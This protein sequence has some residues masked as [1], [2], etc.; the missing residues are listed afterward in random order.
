VAKKTTRKKYS[1]FA[2]IMETT[3]QRWKNTLNSEAPPDVDRA[4]ALLKKA[5]PDDQVFVVESPLQFYLAQA[6]I[7]GR[8]SRLRATRAC[9]MFYDID[10]AF[11]SKLQKVGRPKDLLAQPGRWGNDLETRTQ[12]MVMRDFVTTAWWPNLD[13]A[14]KLRPVTARS[15]LSFDMRQTDIV[16]WLVDITTFELKYHYQQLDKSVDQFDEADRRE[17]RQLEYAICFDIHRRFISNACVSIYSALSRNVDD[18]LN[19]AYDPALH[20][21]D[22]SQAEM[23][24]RMCGLKEKE[25]WRYEIFH[26]VPAIMRFNGAFLILS[27]RPD[28]YYED[29]RLHNDEG[30]AIEWADGKKEWYIKGHR[31]EMYGKEIVTEP[32]K[33]TVHMLQSINNEETRRIAIERLGWEKYLNTIEAK[34]I[35]KSENWVD[36]TVEALIQPPPSQNKW[37][38]VPLRMLLA[39]RSTARKYFIAVPQEVEANITAKN[40]I[41]RTLIRAGAYRNS[42]FLED[43]F[44]PA[45]EVVKIADCATAQNWLA[46]G[47][48]TEFLPYAKHTIRVVGAS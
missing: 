45:P 12:A 30:P 10:P 44:E 34:V 11:L 5:N 29:N 3:V 41:S 6:V 28:M 9:K 38:R 4:T 14:K 1:K 18:I 16:K 36:N 21:N 43:N 2:N 48:V 46:G 20:F 17:L 47:A 26:C 24:G 33:L 32:E 39:C 40:L 37:E 35:D 25:A 7:R 42:S 22:V 15:P 31:L 27:K 8:L 23:V 13:A 19:D